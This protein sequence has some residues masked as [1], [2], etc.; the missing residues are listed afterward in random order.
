MKKLGNPLDAYPAFPAKDQQHRQHQDPQ[1]LRALLVF[2]QLRFRR[3]PGARSQ[4]FTMLIHTTG[5]LQKF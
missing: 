2:P 1:P 3:L 4:P 5:L